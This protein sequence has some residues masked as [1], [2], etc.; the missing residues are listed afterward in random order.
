MDKFY[1]KERQIDMIIIIK[2]EFSKNK[3]R[4]VK[5]LIA[6]KPKENDRKIERKSSIV[7]NYKDN[8]I[9]KCIY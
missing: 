1:D 4:S 8:I 7:K 5:W 3:N 6:H 9:F 2:K